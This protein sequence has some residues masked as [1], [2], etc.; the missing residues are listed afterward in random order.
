MTLSSSIRLGLG[1]AACVAALILATLWG[2]VPARFGPC[3]EDP[4]NPYMIAHCLLGPPPLVVA[5][6]L[7]ISLLAIAGPAVLAARAAPAFKVIAGA[8]ATSF[9]SLFGLLARHAVMAQ[10]F[11]VGSMP[12][13]NV[14]AIVGCIFF[15]FGA[16]V[17]WATARWWPNN[18]LERTRDS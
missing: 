17:A 5:L 18:S 16:L 3:P 11:D 7:A 4:A 12:S 14:V 9:S 8:V 2:E 13:L 15:L 1:F 6:K 10:T